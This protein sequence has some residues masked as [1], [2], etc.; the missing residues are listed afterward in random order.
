[1]LSGGMDPAEVTDTPPE[2]FVRLAPPPPLTGD[3]VAHARPAG[4]VVFSLKARE[5]AADVR[6]AARA[7]AAR[8]A[9]EIREAAAKPQSLR[10]SG[11][12]VLAHVAM[13]WGLSLT[14]LVCTVRH[15][16]RRLNGGG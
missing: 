10:A 6:L 8:R 15:G 16:S 2:G 9:K 12:E 5:H 4:G 11:K 13:S 14:C 3:H 7:R 1:M